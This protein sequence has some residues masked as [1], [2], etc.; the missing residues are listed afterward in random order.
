MTGLSVSWDRPDAMSNLD[1]AGQRLRQWKS[2]T[3]S[4]GTAI[5]EGQYSWFCHM[6]AWSRYWRWTAPLPSELFGILSLRGTL[7][8]VRVRKAWNSSH[9]WLK[10]LLSLAHRSQEPS[11]DTFSLHL[12]VQKTPALLSHCSA[13]FHLAEPVSPFPLI[14]LFYLTTSMCSA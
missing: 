13:S 4:P 3:K 8:Q 9:S 11:N 10:E 12:Q 7:R 2:L 6:S 5:G 14:K 1:W